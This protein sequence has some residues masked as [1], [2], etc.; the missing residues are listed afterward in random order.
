MCLL[1]FWAARDVWFPENPHGTELSDALPASV[2]EKRSLF[3]SFECFQEFLL[4]TTG[5]QF[6]RQHGK[7]T[8]AH[9]AVVAAGTPETWFGLEGSHFFAVHPSWDSLC[10]N[11]WT[12]Y[13][14]FASAES[15]TLLGLL[16]YGLDDLEHRKTC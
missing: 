15:H 16:V 13:M 5:Y 4:T 7:E 9:R 14:E 11:E 6:L 3:E 8:A 1:L 10:A 12:E 2:V